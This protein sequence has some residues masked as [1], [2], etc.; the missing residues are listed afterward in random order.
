MGGNPLS[1]IK[2]A[3]VTTFNGIPTHISQ[4]TTYSVY[5]VVNFRNLSSHVFSSLQVFLRDAKQAE[6]LLSQQDNFLSKEEVPVSDNPLYCTLVKAFPS[7]PLFTRFLFE[8]FSRK[9]F[10]VKPKPYPSQ[11][12]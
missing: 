12:V 2:G 11:S 5:I 1:K 10:G 9:H 7:P 3:G 6:V 4:C 8:S